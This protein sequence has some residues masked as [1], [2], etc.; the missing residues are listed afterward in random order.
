M[1]IPSEETIPFLSLKPEIKTQKNQLIN[2]FLSVLDSGFFVRG[3]EVEAFESEFAAYSH[4][5]NCVGVANGLDALS[6]ILRAMGIGQGDEV[7]VPAHTFIAT[8]LA[9]SQC[10][11]TPV[12][13][14][15]ELETGNMNPELIEQSITAKSKA[16]IPVHLYGRPANMLQICS[17]A[18]RHGLKVIEDAA[19][20]HGAMCQDKYVGMF[21]D[22]AAFS[23]YP[24]KNLGAF[25][26]GGAVVTKDDKL[27]ANVRLLANY[28]SREKYHHI[29]QGVNSRLDEMQAAFLRIRLTRLE[30][31]N[32]RRNEI[33]QRYSEAFSEHPSLQIPI[34]SELG[35]FQVWHLYVIRHKD[36]DTLQKKLQSFGIETQIHYP[37]APY[38]SE[39]YLSQCDQ[40]FPVAEA[41]SLTCLSLPMGPH[42]SDEQVRH[43]IRK[44]LDAA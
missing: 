23:F 24:G 16:I 12:G 20:A 28:G 40:L 27:A 6:L 22:A 43:V 18:S 44:V 38:Q 21:S 32:E 13:V 14:D 1:S 26:D 41:W 29:C 5:P 11:A 36:R 7:L 15:V 33:A 3:A 8:W 39:A 25:G 37:I 31:L 10:G 9:V 35:M 19:Q 2:A 30:A 4:A 42:L 17:I 34:A